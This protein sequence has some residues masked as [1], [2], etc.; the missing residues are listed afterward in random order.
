MDMDSIRK[1]LDDFIKLDIGKKQ[2]PEQTFMQLSGYPHYENVCSN[3][4]SFFF[5]TG[6]THGYKDLFVRS[7]LECT[8][9]ALSVNACHTET[10]ERECK[11][12]NNKRID[13]IFSTEAYVVGIENKIYSNVYNDLNDYEAYVAK[14]SEENDKIPV[15]IL[16]SIY[17]NGGAIENSGFTNI[18]YK[19]LI[20]KL[21]TNLGRYVLSANTKWTVFLND[22]IQTLEGLTEETKMDRELLDF[23]AGN[24]DDIYKLFEA[25]KSIEHFLRE[26]AKRL[27]AFVSAGENSLVKQCIST[28]GDCY[29]EYYIEFSGS[30]KIADTII[31]EVY[32]DFSTIEI[33]IGTENGSSTDKKMLEEY[34]KDIGVAFEQFSINEC[35]LKLAEYD[36]L[37]AEEIIAGK[38][39][40]FLCI[41]LDS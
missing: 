14:L 23:F 10:V 5:D 37:V 4:L 28:Q 19:R 22:F 35:Y 13:I 11:T 32:I 2:Q 30:K 21:K 36:V 17:D 25:K 39:N 31:L 1:M 34:L 33:V 16:L 8:H 29:V 20:E 18:T 12:D 41:V 7:L 24:W 26:K 9:Q 27:K 40:E 3:I 15:C 6:G 38:F